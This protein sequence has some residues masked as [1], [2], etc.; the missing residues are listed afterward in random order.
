MRYYILKKQ[1][2]SQ[3][4]FIKYWAD[5]YDDKSESEIALHI[6][7]PK[8]HPIFDRNVYR[9]MAYLR[10]GTIKEIPSKNIDKQRIY[11]EEY[12]PFYNE[13]RDYEDR[14]VDQALFSFGK[15]LGNGKT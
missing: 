14:K 8:K 10:S 9:A 2:A 5:Q 15:N 3:V 11:I 1:E 12:I 13:F 7:H 4:E 6:M